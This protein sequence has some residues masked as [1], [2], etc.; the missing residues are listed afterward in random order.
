VETL[1]RSLNRY[2]EK[3]MLILTGHS[4]PEALT[5]KIG[6]ALIF[7]RLWE[8]SGIKKALGRLLNGA[9]SSSMS[10]GRSFSPC[11]IG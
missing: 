5:I 8:Q 10:N 3:A 2:S 9:N 6:P 4:D 11:C 1:I 7:E